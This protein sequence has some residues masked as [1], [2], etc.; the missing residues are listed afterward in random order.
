MSETFP[1]APPRP[2]GWRLCEAMPPPWTALPEEILSCL[3]SAKV[4]YSVC[5]LQAIRAGRSGGGKPSD[6]DAH[7]ND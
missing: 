3:E 7:G 4:L 2:C 1:S 5:Q 6:S